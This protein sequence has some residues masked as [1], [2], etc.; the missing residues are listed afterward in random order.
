MSYKLEPAIW[1]RD[2]GQRILC[3][4]RC[5]LIIAWMSK[6]QGCM[7]LATHY[8]E[9]GRHVARLRRRRRAYAPTSNTASHDDH[10]KINSWVRYF[11]IRV[12][13][14]GSA[15]RPFGPPELRYK[16]LSRFIHM[17]SPLCFSLTFKAP[18]SLFVSSFSH[19]RENKRLFEANMRLEQENDNL[20]HE[21]VTTKVELHSKLAEVCLSSFIYC[22][23]NVFAS[24]IFWLISKDRK[25]FR[26]LRRFSKLE[27]V[28]ATGNFFFRLDEEYE[29]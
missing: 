5:Q 15:W 27:I 1:P 10:E 9:S 2:T 26:Y 24:T 17:F 11:P 28:R 4:D 19:Q 29:F 20:A 21:L 6:H 25:L 8:L 3:F 7:S 23:M 22:E 13:V 14:W 18:H 16:V 12:W